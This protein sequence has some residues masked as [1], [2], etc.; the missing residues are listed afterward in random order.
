MAGEGGLGLAVVRDLEAAGTESTWLHVP[1]DVE[2][3]AGLS[4]APDA[5]AIVTRDDAR[6]LR[7]ALLTA[8]EHP[9]ARLVVT[10]FDRT[11]ALQ[12]REAVRGCIVVSM[13]DLVVSSLAAACIGDETAAVRRTGD[14]LEVVGQDARSTAFEIQPTPRTTAALDRLIGVLRPFDPSARF[15]VDGLCAV[16][17]MLVAEVALGMAALHEDFVTALYEGVRTL[18]A[19]G[20][21]DELSH[22]G[23]GTRLL[24]TAIMLGTLAA[25][26][27][28][29][30]ALVNRLL[31]ERRVAIVGRRAMPRRDHVIIVGVGQVGLRLALLLRDAGI[32]VVGVERDPDSFGARV[33][34]RY[35]IPIVIA[36]GG[37][38]ELLAALS[39]HRARAL[40]AV[41]SDD[42]TNIAVALAARAVDPD[43]R[44]VL[45][46]GDGEIAAE[47]R[48]LLHLGTVCDAHRLAGAGL[49]AAVCG[50][51]PGAVVAQPDGRV[52][53][54]PD[55]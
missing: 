34:R 36:E 27:V 10:I 26:A 12:L 47:T 50:W 53:L 25:V 13:A 44:V 55:A 31:D 48:S 7:L 28:F 51:R 38:R 1:T 20:P 33:G 40:A 8:H 5:V 15:L 3:S 21:S 37:D 29:T 2:F 54:L 39:L 24:A 14:A 11:V 41:S 35:G 6:A 32:P 16:M 23:D 19:V 43:L 30:A 45:R 18:V 17:A 46:A 9:T 52:A 42:L 4:T 49:A 22:A